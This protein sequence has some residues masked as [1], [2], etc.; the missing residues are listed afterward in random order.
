MSETYVIETISDML[1]VPP[2]RRKVMLHDLETALE[3][4]EFAFGEAAGQHPI[5]PLDWTDDGDHSVS[6]H[7]NGQEILKLEIVEAPTTAQGGAR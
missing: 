5:G 3:L 2:D 7:N 1:K 6:L 4:H